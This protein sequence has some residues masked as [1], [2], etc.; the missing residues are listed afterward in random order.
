MDN[1]I[2]Q[3]DWQNK[4]QDPIILAA[5]KASYDELN[6]QQLD[7]ISE[8]LKNDQEII[9]I[10]KFWE[11]LVARQ[12][13]LNFRITEIKQKINN[14]IKSN[15]TSTVAPASLPQSEEKKEVV[16]VAQPTPVP[17]MPS[18]SLLEQLKEAKNKELELHQS[19]TATAIDIANIQQ[20]IKDLQNKLK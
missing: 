19:T 4:Y 8:K 17:F 15:N 10:K 6:K 16:P 1:Q 7:L 13:D 20:K 5:A 11:S 14:I 18:N 3:L 2:S 12:K 9:A